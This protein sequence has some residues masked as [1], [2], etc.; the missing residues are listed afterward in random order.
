MFREKITKFQSVIQVGCKVRLF[1]K[2]TLL[3]ICTPLIILIFDILV[4]HNLTR[5]MDQNQDKLRL[6]KD[7]QDTFKYIFF[8]DSFF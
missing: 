8:N 6:F 3:K 7:A 1:R 2:S 5:Y 4:D